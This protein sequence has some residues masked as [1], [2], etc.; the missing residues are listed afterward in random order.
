MSFLGATRRRSS[1]FVIRIGCV[2]L[3]AS[4]SS[5]RIPAVAAY[6]SHCAHLRVMFVPVKENRSLFAEDC[7]AHQAVSIRDGIFAGS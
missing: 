6:D 2:C 7:G 4:L 3:E 5:P 1:I